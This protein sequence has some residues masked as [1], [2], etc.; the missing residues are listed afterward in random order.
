MALENSNPLKREYV[1]HIL[2]WG[3]VL[4]YPYIKFM[5]REGGY[6][7]TFLHEL[8]SV[9]F[10]IIP[11][12]TLYYWWLPLKSENRKKSL[13]IL[14]LVFTASIFGFEFTDSL[15]HDYGFHPFRW[16]QLVS[17]VVKNI[18]FLTF[19]FALYIVKGLLKQK[20]ALNQITTEKKQAELLALKAQ[21]TPHFLFNTLNGLYADALK[22]D[23]ALADS[24]LQL[25]T[26]TR[27]FLKEGQQASVSIKEELNHIE[28]YIQLQKK[29]LGN[30]VKVEFQ[31]NLQ[32]SSLQIAPLLLIPIIENAFKYAS[33]LRGE[34]HSID[35]NVS[36]R[37]EELILTC[38]NPFNENT[39][40][41]SD[42][43]WTNS[44]IGLS[45]VK[46]RLSLQYPDSHH[47]EASAKENGF[48]V[49]L[50]IIL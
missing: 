42:T 22:H 10:I 40:S 23:N 36:E 16:K 6:S 19:F 43:E 8:N 2:L 15:F 20:Q 30:K 4:L 7:E 27:Y 17:G 47:L 12:Y 28:N 13:I 32:D 18:P 38:I 41:T 44:G 48:S 35:I 49:N 31:K 21:V 3:S 14:I 46:K 1:I 9:L 25:S 5:G 39:I 29:R 37:N 34:E 11:S 24:I 50:K 45:N 33:M 26:N